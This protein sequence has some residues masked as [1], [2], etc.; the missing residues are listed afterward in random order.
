[1]DLD[2]AYVPFFLGIGDQIDFSDPVF[3]AKHKKETGKEVEDDVTA[4]S[5]SWENT[6]FSGAAH[7]W[8][9][10]EFLRKYWDGPIVLKGIQSVHDAKNAVET[11]VDGIVVS[12]HGNPSHVCGRHH[13]LTPP[14]WSLIRWCR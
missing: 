6:I 9:E 7:T 1:M 10:L 13:I 14:E 8:E 5:M 4:A 2:N 3:R 11:G 12:N